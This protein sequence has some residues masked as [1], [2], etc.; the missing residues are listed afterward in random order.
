MADLYV[1]ST[2]SNTAP[3]DTWAKAATSFGTA[4]TA[5]LA[6]DKIHVASGFTQSLG[7][8]TT[9][10]FAGTPDNP[11]IVVCENTSTGALVEE[12]A[13]ISTTGSFTLNIAGGLDSWCLNY[14]AGS[15]AVN[16]SLGLGQTTANVVQRFHLCRLRVNAT[17]AS[18]RILASLST[19]AAARRI[20]L[21]RVKLYAGGTSSTNGV[22][23][24]GIVDVEM[25]GGS[26]EAPSFVNIVAPNQG[27]GRGSRVRL[28]GV[29]L[30]ACRSDVNLMR[31]G[32]NSLELVEAYDCK[33]PAGW[34][35]GPFDATS[36]PDIGQQADMWNCGN[37]SALFS[38]MGSRY[39]GNLRSNTGVYRNGGSSI[40]SVG[41]S[42]ELLPNAAA[43]LGGAQ[44]ETPWFGKW[45][46]TTGAQD[47]DVEIAHAGSALNNNQ[48][49]LEVRFMGE[50]GSPI[51]TRASNRCANPN[52]APTTHP[53][54]TETWTGSGAGTKQRLTVPVNPQRKGYFQARVVLADDV[55]SSLFV[56]AKLG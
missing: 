3:Y 21:D 47:I 22:I 23:A 25:Y 4:V 50:S 7:A 11:V 9:Y 40:D 13:T 14:E 37:S 10:T 54:S 35:G 2:G 55:V 20:V 49:W 17:G 32:G 39:A 31:S 43:T 19:N 30:S 27:T 38:Y 24:P 6:G 12:G 41:Y 36:S 18:A 46:A 44:I 5:A 53:T 26:I 1:S 15:G 34:T 8:N 16:T 28:Y 42:I 48:V 33:M 56:D 51:G 29:D 52:T 45:E